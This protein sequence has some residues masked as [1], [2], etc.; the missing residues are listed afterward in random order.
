MIAVEPAAEEPSVGGEFVVV[1]PARADQRLRVL[2]VEDDDAD[3]FLVSE[4]LAEVPEQVV[5][6]RV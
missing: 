1:T 2:L 4:L 5:V 3:A 6:N